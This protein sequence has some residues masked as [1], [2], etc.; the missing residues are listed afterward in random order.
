MEFFSLTVMP[1][2]RPAVPIAAFV[3]TLLYFL[4]AGWAKPS[5]IEHSIKIVKDGNELDAS[6]E[7]ETGD[8]VIRT[9]A[10]VLNQRS[11]LG[12]RHAVQ[13]GEEHSIHIL[14]VNPTARLQTI[15]GPT[16]NCSTV[17]PK[18]RFEGA[19]PLDRVPLWL[20]VDGL[21]SDLL[22]D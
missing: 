13:A 19:R 12:R 22:P 1:S 6:A 14:E 7:G 10:T 15:V 17:P 16:D 9:F 8:D 11:L 21:K 4:P 5:I 2:R 20:D 18:F 3:T